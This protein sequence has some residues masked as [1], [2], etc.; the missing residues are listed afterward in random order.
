MASYCHQ[1]KPEHF[2]QLTWNIFDFIFLRKKRCLGMFS[3][4]DA[5]QSHRK[6][7]F[8][9]MVKLKNSSNRNVLCCGTVPNLFGTTESAGLSH[10]NRQRSRKRASLYTAVYCVLRRRERADTLGLIHTRRSYLKNCLIHEKHPKTQ[11]R[12]T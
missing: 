4:A 1:N 7:I 12:Q 6:S 2:I 10:F 11:N 3:A 8:E 5:K 9:F